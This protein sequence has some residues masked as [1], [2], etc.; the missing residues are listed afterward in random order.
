MSQHNGSPKSP[1]TEVARNVAELAR[2]AMTLAELQAELLKTELK[3]SLRGFLVPVALVAAA[4]MAAL[5]STAALLLSFAY[6]LVEF[7]GWST[8]LSLFVASVVGAAAAS[9]AVAVAWRKLRQLSN[10]LD[11]SREELRRNMQWIKQALK[12]RGNLRRGAGKTGSSQYE[13]SQT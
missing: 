4:L 5:S 3:E 1:P 9:I 6:V 10:G 11:R 12:N 8:A 7:A 2:D 13:A